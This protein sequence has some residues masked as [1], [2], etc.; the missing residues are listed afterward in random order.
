MGSDQTGGPSSQ[1]G[2]T[3][4][5]AAGPSAALRAA[6][7]E[8]SGPRA[9]KKRKPTAAGHSVET[10]P[11]R[12][13]VGG[14]L[15]LSAAAGSGFWV[16]APGRWIAA[17]DLVPWQEVALA[18][19]AIGLALIRGWELARK[20][21]RFVLLLAAVALIPAAGILIAQRTPW[22][23][24]VV[25]ASAFVFLAGLV[26]WLAKGRLSAAG[27]VLRLLVV[28]AGVA[29]IVRF[30]LVLEHP[31]ANRIRHWAIADRSLNDRELGMSLSLPAP[32]L[33]LQIEQDVFPTAEGT[34][35]VLAEPRRGGRALLAS[36]TPHQVLSLDAFL[37][38][39]LGARELSADAELSRSDVYLGRVRARKR[40][41]SWQR[42][43]TLFRDLMV[44]GK[45]GGVYWLLT[46]WM[47]DDGSV[48]PAQQLES[49]ANGLALE[50]KMKASLEQALQEVTEQVPFLTSATAEAV[51]AFSGQ[52]SLGPPEAFRQALELT[53][54]GRRT[55]SVGEAEELEGLSDEVFA[56]LPRRDRGRLRRYVSRVSDGQATHPEDDRAMLLLM[57]DAALKLPRTRLSRLQDLHE[58]AIGA[59]VAG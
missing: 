15:L 39:A 42:A 36:T 30:G 10:Q 7:R 9:A 33:A 45:D 22:P 14:M 57:K 20:L 59:A 44:V 48:L 49:L 25:V 38:R 43:G 32:W 1:G 4:P 6:V 24:L 8:A 55:L 51:F 18:E 41:G 28:L 16:F 23:A 3:G 50:G 40:E 19:V 11:W 2:G 53:A 29:G 27:I 35:L 37:D 17:L 12:T 31:D 52:P 34:R 47:P 46:A 21:V 56:E 26:A 54:R 58:Q 5:S 13:T